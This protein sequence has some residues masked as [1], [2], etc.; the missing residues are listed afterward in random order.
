[1]QCL[2]LANAA[3]TKLLGAKLGQIVA[4]GTILLL[5]GDLGSGKTTFVQ[6]LGAAL[7]IQDP[8][9][10]PTFALIHEYPEARIPLYH[11]DLY[12]LQP[13]ETAALNLEDYW[14]GDYPAGVVAI[15]WA[16]RLKYLPSEYLL[17]Q[18]ST[19]GSGLKSSSEAES[20]AESGRIA[21]LEAVGRQPQQLLQALFEAKFEA[22]QDC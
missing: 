21:E 8:I 14:E 7:C 3:A 17:I 1:M 10:S 11:F 20:G 18:L 5:K 15:E 6:G 22:N 12:R 13:D 2:T 16:E 19:S 9:V 4:A